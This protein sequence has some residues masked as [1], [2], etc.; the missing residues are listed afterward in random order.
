MEDAATR[1]TVSFWT[2][3][4]VVALQVIC[5]SPLLLSA[6]YPRGTSVA[7]DTLYKAVVEPTGNDILLIA[8]L[9]LITEPEAE[10]TTP[11]AKN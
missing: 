7:P 5:F 2:T 6:R 4:V 8:F 11:K 1:T 9:K 3:P 10:S